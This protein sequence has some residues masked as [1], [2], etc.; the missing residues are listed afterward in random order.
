MLVWEAQKLPR[1]SLWRATE[2]LLLQVQLCQNAMVQIFSGLVFS[3]LFF[4]FESIYFT[5]LFTS[6]SSSS[7]L[8]SLLSAEAAVK[9]TLAWEQHGKAKG[10]KGKQHQIAVYYFIS[11]EEQSIV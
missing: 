3:L 5:P 8:S 6:S 11:M 9:E 4:F 7:S 10:F 1:S 2:L